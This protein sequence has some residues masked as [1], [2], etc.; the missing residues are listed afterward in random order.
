MKRKAN[1]VNGTHKKLKF[2]KQTSTNSQ[3]CIDLYFHKNTQSDTNQNISPV[4]DH[5]ILDISPEPAHNPR[6][7]KPHTNPTPHPKGINAFDILL[8][9]AVTAYK[10]VFYLE[11]RGKNSIG[12]HIWKYHFTDNLAYNWISKVHKL[13]LDARRVIELQL[14]TN[15]HMIPYNLP[16]VPSHTFA[17]SML[18]SILQ[19]NVRLGRTEATLRTSLQLSAQFTLHELTRRFCV[20]A[21]EDSLLHPDYPILAW[22]MACGNELVY[23]REL[24][25]TVFQV[26]SDV[27]SVQYK[28]FLHIDGNIDMWDLYKQG[29]PITRSIL[30][31]GFYKGMYGDVT[32][33]N[34]SFI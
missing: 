6:S 28:D 20:I 24:V 18:K 34:V 9:H 14:A 8:N 22:C 13:K 15:L 32:M 16:T 10:S 19:K 11:Y 2:S 3:A 33:L 7:S 4:T 23:S 1:S 27:T 21:L 17:K 12:R 29:H 30:I 26:I 31:R 5:P 25:E